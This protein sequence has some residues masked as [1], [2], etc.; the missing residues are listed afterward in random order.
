MIFAGARTVRS[1]T[2]RDLPLQCLGDADEV[3]DASAPRP[4]VSGSTPAGGQRRVD[5]LARRQGAQH[6]A[7]RLAPVG[8]RGVDDREH[9]LA[10][11]AVVVRGS[12]RAPGDQPGVDV[13]RRARRRCGRSAPARR[14]SA[15]QAA[16]TDGTPYTFEPGAAASRSA[17]SACTITSPRSSDGSSA[18]RCSSTGTETL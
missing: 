15:Y 8:E 11:L 14:T 4:R 9:L 18:S 5:D 17:T 16:L 1:L 2:L 12:R 7:Q 10:R 3:L 6:P 13:R